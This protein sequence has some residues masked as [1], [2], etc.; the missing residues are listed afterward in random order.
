MNNLNVM[1]RINSRYTRLSKG[2]KKIA[3]FIIKSVENAAQMTALSL[4][5]RTGVSEATVVRFATDLD[6]NGFPEFQKA[7]RQYVSSK[8]TASQRI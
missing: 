8:L 5:E 1:Q 7:L 6:Y 4:A 3:D 2:R